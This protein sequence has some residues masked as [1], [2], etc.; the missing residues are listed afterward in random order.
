MWYGQCVIC[1]NI[2]NDHVCNLSRRACRSSILDLEVMNSEPTLVFWPTN[3][4]P[5]S[6][7][8]LLLAARLGEG[9]ALA[10]LAS[11]G[12]ALDAPLAGG[13]RWSELAGGGSEFSSSATWCMALGPARMSERW[14]WVFAS[15]VLR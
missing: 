1:D 8:I 2:C 13:T 6:Q 4:T 10:S 9:G 12:L 3:H 15:A 11:W 7:S 5:F 14:L